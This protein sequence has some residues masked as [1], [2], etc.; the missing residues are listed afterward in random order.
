ML[1][2]LYG[3]QACCYCN[4]FLPVPFASLLD[5]DRASVMMVGSC[6]CSYFNTKLLSY[7]CQVFVYLHDILSAHLVLISNVLIGVLSFHYLY[8]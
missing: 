6:I 5:N 7:V 1:L 3:S 2:L 4:A 8:L